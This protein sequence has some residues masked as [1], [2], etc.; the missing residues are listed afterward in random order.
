MNSFATTYLSFSPDGKE[1]LVNLSGEHIYLYNAL[2]YEEALKYKFVEESADSTDSYKPAA[3][4][5]H[6][7][8]MNGVRRDGEMAALSQSLSRELS[9]TAVPQ[10]AV[11]NQVQELKEKGSDFHNAGKYIE[12]V[13]EFS[14]AIKL[15]PSWHVLY[16]LRAASL[17]G[18][19]W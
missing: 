4:L 15:C 16:T 18:R 19:R 11:D 13:S 7:C 5:S 8:T 9:P 2:H 12:A 6:P 3:S 10:C 14:A 1:L 17:Y